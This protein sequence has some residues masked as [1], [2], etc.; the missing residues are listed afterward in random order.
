MILNCAIIDED[1]NAL[2]QLKKYVDEMPTFNLI[3]ACHTAIEAVDGIR[4]I[5]L[6][7]CF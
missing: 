2:E 7:F 6:T 1:P 5:I 4:T 3:G